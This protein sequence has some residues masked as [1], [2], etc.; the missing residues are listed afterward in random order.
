MR[1]GKIF[2]SISFFC[3]CVL[4]LFGLWIVEKGWLCMSGILGSIAYNWSQPTMKNRVKIIHTRYL[5]FCL[6]ECLISVFSIF[7]FLDFGSC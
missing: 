2:P 4:I 7:V 6:Y 1:K 5:F 3:L